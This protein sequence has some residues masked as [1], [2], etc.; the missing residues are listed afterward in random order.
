MIEKAFVGWLEAWDD[1]LWGA[2]RKAIN[3]K[4]FKIYDEVVVIDTPTWE[5]IQRL[6]F[7]DE[8][9]RDEFLRGGEG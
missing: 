2:R 7:P 3:V 1:A 5:K 4:T 8:K 9:K 6:A